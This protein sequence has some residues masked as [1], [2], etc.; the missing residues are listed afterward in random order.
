MTKEEFN[1]V[2]RSRTKSLAVRVIKMYGKLPKTDETRIVGKQLIR[3]STSVAANY[4]SVC[5]ARSKAEFFA[6]LSIVVEETDET[7][8]WLEILEEANIV[9]AEK[10]HALKAETLA[11]LS[12]FAKARS[13]TY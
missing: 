3:S 7:L 11:L 12:I 9:S 5:R 10:L 13:N 4:R 8:F 6:K 2:I 1:T